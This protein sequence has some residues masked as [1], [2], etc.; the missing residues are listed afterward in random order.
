MSKL[1]LSN[2]GLSKLA[3]SNIDPSNIVS[4][5]CFTIKQTPRATR[6]VGRVGL[7]SHSP[8]G[9][10]VRLSFE[11]PAVRLAYV[12]MIGRPWPGVKGYS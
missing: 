9:G 12:G 3:L 5:D 1:D 10:A 11:G 7:P 4:R 8:C 6:M 2:T